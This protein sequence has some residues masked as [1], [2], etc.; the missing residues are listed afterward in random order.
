MFQKFAQFFNLFKRND[1]GNMVVMLATAMPVLLTSG[2]LAMDYATFSMK[3]SDLQSAAD[4][5]A[6]AGAKQMALASSTDS[7]V[8]STATT[9]FL[10]ELSG[11]A[12][13]AVPTVT[14]DRK[15]G[16]VKVAVAEI[17]TPAFASFIDASVTPIK[18]TATASLAGETRICILALETTL[19]LTF[20][21]L[22]KSHVTA[23]GCGVY[24]NSTDPAA[25]S[26]GNQAT[27][28]ATV[29]CSAGGIVGKGSGSS[30]NFITDCP[31]I[32]DPL[33]GRAAPP[34]K[35][36]N[37][38][39][40]VATSGSVTLAPGVYCGG[41]EI[42]GSATATFS[43][44]NYVI[45]NGVFKIANNAS[46]TGKNVSFYLTGT[47]AVLR[48]VG[49]ASIDFSG[50]EDGAMA[51]LLF[52]EDRNSEPRR[53]HN[54]NAS[55][56]HNLTGTIYLPQGILLVDPA[57]EVAED[58]AYTAIIADQLTVQRGPSL[59]LNTNYTAS[60]VP[61]PEGVKTAATVVLSN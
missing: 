32:A 4:A 17:W 56:A 54:I 29:V 3:R 41:L 22:H 28:D 60:N 44:G 46:V 13:N 55:N 38:S 25:V 61:V 53:T 30:S 19:P 7:A 27:V 15:K 6:L 36:C 31:A 26:I 58:S 42:S 52:F 11:N 33:A 2:G 8:I 12:A 23:K 40:Y 18:V 37:F 43:P 5:S 20:E 24:A 51:G 10:S 34:F 48:F 49:N 1:R 57:A 45:K 47:A 16:S 50:A 21:M 14:I 9:L 35:G 59:V 39:N